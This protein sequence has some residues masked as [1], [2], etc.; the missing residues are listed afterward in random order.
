MQK[1]SNKKL[2][3]KALVFLMVVALIG[4][5]ASIAAAARIIPPEGTYVI[6][7][8]EQKI[9][10]GITESEVITNNSSGNNQNIDYF[11]EV[12][13]KGT[14]TTKIISGYAD[15]NANKW[16]M[17]RVTDQAKAA[18]KAKGYNVVAGINADFYNMSTGQPIGALVMEGKVY[19]GT[20]GR[21]YFAILKDGTAAIREGN[22]P[23]DDVESAVGGDT[24]MVKDGKLVNLDPNSTYQNI[25]YSRTAIGIKDDGSVVTF[26]THGRNYPISCGRTYKEVAEMLIGKGC[27]TV[28]NLDGGGSSTYASKYEGS[29][30]FLCRNTPSDGNERTVSSS[31]LVVSTAKATGE[32]DHAALSPN[33]LVYTPNSKVEFTAKGVDSAGGEATLPSDV[34]W[35][36]ADS[37]YG[38]IDSKGIFTSNGT[39]GEVK[40]NLKSDGK[41]VGT[42]SILVE[43]PDSIT[44]SNDEVSLGFSKSSDLAMSV[45]YKGRDVI[46]KDGDF[47]WTLS[48]EKL[49]TFDGN[50]FTS[51]DSETVN[52][53]ATATCVYDENVSGTVHLIIG[54][55]PSVVLDFEDKTDSEGNTIKAEDYFSITR[56]ANDTNSLLLIGDYGRGAK[57]S[58]KVIDLDSGEPVRFGSHALKV[59]YDFSDVGAATDGVTIGFTEAGKPIEGNPTGIGMWVYAPEGT[60]NL[61][62]RIEL[63]DGSNSLVRL[64]F[65][66]EAKI[67]EG[68][69]N[70]IDWS[71]WKYVEASFPENMRGPFKMRKGQAIR[72]MYVP[73]TQ[74]GF[75]TRGETKDDGTY[76]MVEVPKAQRK[77]SLYID[78]LQ[79]V[80]GAN[81]DDIDNPVIDSITANDTEIKNGMTI[82][83]NTI[84]FKSLYSDVENK[85]TSGIDYDTVRM[86]LDGVNMTSEKNCVNVPGDNAINLYDAKLSNGKHSIKVLV[87]D[88]FGNETTETR[89]FTVKGDKEY[90]TVELSPST[91]GN[92]ILNKNYD[93]GLK[94]QKIEEIDSVETEIKINNDFKDYEVKFNDDFDGSA[95]YDAKNSVIKITATR[96]EG[97]STQSGKGDIAT[98]SF[99]VPKEL[100]KGSVFTYCAQR[101]L[102]SYNTEQEE[103]YTKSFATAQESIEVL[104][105][106]TIKADQM[107]VGF[108]GKIYVTDLDNKP[109]ADASIY[110]GDEEIGK[111]NEEGYLQTDV[112]CQSAGK[113][114]LYAAKGEDISYSINVQTTTTA[115]NE[116]GLPEY[117]IS[118]ATT[119]SATSKNITWMSNPKSSDA[120]AIM[121]IAKTSDYDKDGEAAFKNI[122][123]TSKLQSFLGSSDDNLNK[124]VRVNK[125]LTTGLSKNTQYTYRVG[126][127]KQWSEVKT[128]KTNRNGTNT[129]FFVIGDT[130]ASNQDNVDQIAANLASDGNYSF[131]IQTG[132][133]V[134][135]A[136]TYSHWT[137]VLQMF[138]G[139]YI[140]G[141]DM[142]HVLG[143]HEYMGDLNG[144]TAQNIYNLPN[145]RRYSVEY[146]NVYVA[147]I[148]YT[149]SKSQLKEDL[150]WLRQDAKASK[151]KWKVLTMHQPAY[152]TNV[153][154][155]NEMIN[156][157]VP[158]AVEEAGIDFVFSGH[159]HTYARTEP[160]KDG[161]VNEKDGTVYYICGST[162]EKSYGI[163]NNPN[164]HFAIATQDYNGIYLTASTTDDTFTVTTHDVDGSV[165]DSYT[166]SKSSEQCKDGHDYVYDGEYLTCNKCGNAKELGN[167]TGF[168]TEEKSGK[169]MYFINGKFQTGWVA[170]P[171]DQYNMYYF[172]EDGLAHDIKV[173]EDIKTTCTTRGHKTFK[174]GDCNITY[175]I[176]Y[177]KASGHEYKPVINISGKTEYICSKCG[178]KSVGLLVN[179]KIRLS[180]TTSAYTGNNKIP[181]VTITTTT[182]KKL[183]KNVD[184]ITQY[185]NN[186]NKGTAT[187]LIT[188]IGDYAGEVV[189]TFNITARD[190][191]TIN[192][193]LSLEY[194]SI[195]YDGNEKTPAV[196]NLTGTISYVSGGKT[197]TKQVTL[198]KDK[199]FTVSYKNNTKPGTAT[200]TVTGIGNYAGTLTK[201]FKINSKETK[202]DKVTGFASQETTT[203]SIKLAWNKVDCDGYEITRYSTG[204]KKYVKI[205]DINNA[206]ITTYTDSGRTSGCYY[207]YKIRAYKVVDGVKVYSE[208]SNI[209]KAT[210][211][212]QAPA[213]KA[214]T[215]DSD[216]ISMS[217]NA[218]G[219]A[220]GYEVYR[221]DA[222]SEDYKLVKDLNA[223]TYTDKGLAKGTEYSYKVKSYRVVDGVKVYSGD[224]NSISAKIKDSFKLNLEKTTR[225][226][227]EFSWDKIKDA[228]G[229]EILRYSTASKKYVVIDDIDFD[230]L[231]D[232]DREASEEA[233]VYSYLDQGKTSA[234]I[235]NY[236]VKAYNKV[237]GKKVY[238]KE[239]EKL[240]ATTT[241]LTPNVT[242]KSSSK[243]TARLTWKNCSTRATGYKV[244]MAT[245]KNGTYKLVK[246]TTAKSFTKYYLTSGKTY[247]FK[248]R[249]YRT[250][251]GKNIYGDY[252]TIKSIRVK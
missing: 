59:N 125:V 92:P 115:G 66:E 225:N 20:S 82:D 33:N 133:S 114:T 190:I 86:Y 165:I 160:L 121:Q 145:A 136:A 40:V 245:S 219:R 87:R 99:K 124:T 29:N 144:D 158:G 34:T 183:V 138:G 90:N 197:Q 155:S 52:G 137:D 84:N 192:P 184:F 15:Y 232:E 244:Y 198:V 220:S 128:F 50:I 100:K 102:I 119:G 148:N 187:V 56:D 236:K 141:I 195:D 41:V 206:D 177:P 223:T 205:A 185:T 202:V 27:T 101:G 234:T 62:V 108:D 16:K 63:D 31:L 110:K 76:D 214:G 112:L 117:V 251:D 35:E 91:K 208:E 156:E 150:D 213:L 65:T 211:K 53:D 28:L 178:K 105:P 71:G 54:K 30:D 14:S 248:V 68:K 69:M 139:N 159:D 237:D 207:K 49:G 167:Y 23:L 24:I 221:K 199:D 175:T 249:A 72:I 85:N 78:N 6:S 242:V 83:T 200:V 235:Y 43:V 122:E 109:V 75:Y 201:T 218:I 179:Q 79:F 189:K 147:T 104:A 45:K 4:S 193:K 239:S 132:D 224:S 174:C 95:S 157:L 149:T 231:S 182:G 8:T 93:L 227:V 247:Y 243:K 13:L 12:D 233:E 44:F 116:E 25:V 131:G 37:K 127:G 106:L 181:T 26:T 32:F 107:V 77:G 241:P 210:A 7:E 96:K 146:G 191:K 73:G 171:K 120:K 151:C 230:K 222:N 246:T 194:D 142:I 228:T 81:K 42:T 58:A 123:G 98:I 252:S 238:L 64:N 162:G 55:M 153:A 166:K 57:D 152:Y 36:L 22:V 89:Y 46:Y 1:K 18:Q 130:Q 163:V 60:P 140:G 226:S 209:V 9:A 111:T 67:S 61:W 172:G 169:K 250:V 74:Q 143:N 80:Y 216:S 168:V 70:G 103:G 39:T 135:N 126:D 186:V 161:E 217:W 21:P 129:N 10:P 173:A 19:Q 97:V 94:A 170:D 48:D 180:Y 38:K 176:K 5:D 134:D 2:L 212:P 229:Y 11:C 240:K 215:I 51:S 17:Q 196:T 47:K 88:K 154:G 188:G 203:S 204:S 113:N 3:S 118:N 164:F